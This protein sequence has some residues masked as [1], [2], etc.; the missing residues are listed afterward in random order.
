MAQ[1]TH[2]ALLRGVNLGGKNRLPMKTL[3]GLF[4]EVG[5][6]D[7]QT[8]IQSGNVV[9][10][11]APAVSKKIPAQ[12]AKLIADRCGLKTPVVMRTADELRGVAEGNPFLGADPATL[13]VAFLADLPKKA[14]VQ[15]LDAKRSPGDEFVVRGR[16]IY[17][18]LTSGVARTKLTNQYFDSKLS[19]VS[20]VRNWRTVEKLLALAA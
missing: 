16:E 19:T 20:T 6:R 11:A 12:I 17:L 3:A 5:C 9:F 18:H 13:H 10:R 8:Y 7:V 4:A 14:A 2:I 1:V 15:A